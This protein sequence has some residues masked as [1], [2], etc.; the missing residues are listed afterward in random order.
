MAVVQIS[1]IQLRRGKKL[2]SGMPQ[3]A[4]GE[5]AWAID[6]QELYIGNGAVS[7]GAPAVGNTKVL[8]ENDNIL[9]LFDQYQYKPND[10]L[11]QT[12]LD[13][14][15]P[16]QRTLQERLDEGRVNAAS[17]GI[18]GVDDTVDQT[19]LIQNAIYS[20][21]LTTSESNQVALEFD[22]GTYRIT[23]TLYIPSNAYLAGSGKEK[24]VFDFVRGGI[25]SGATLNLLGTSI[26]SAGNYTNL[27]TVTVT[28][29]G[30]G[31]IV[32]VSKTGTGASYTS[33]NTIVTIV[34][35][36]SGYINGDQI[37]ILG[38][39]L[40]GAS[41]TNDLTITLGKRL[42]NPSFDTDTVFEFVNN[43][44]DKGNISTMPS[45]T[46]NNQAKNIVLEGFTVNTNNNSVKVFNF[47]N[48]RNSKIFNVKAKGNNGSDDQDSETSNSPADDGAPLSVPTLIS[49]SIALEMSALSVSYTSS[50]FLTTGN[51]FIDFEAEGFSYGVFSNTEIKNNHFE[52]CTF[53][54]LYMGVSFGENAAIGNNGPIKNQITNCVFDRIARHGMLIAKGYGNRSRGNTFY[55][56]GNNG[57]GNANNVYSQIKFV[58][59]GNTSFQDHFDRAKDLATGSYTEG[60]V[61]EIEGKS[62]KHELVTNSK[63]LST[64]PISVEAFRIPINN[65]SGFEIEYIFKS[66]AYTQM[67]RGK[68]HIAVDSLNNSVQLVDD[69]EYIGTAGQEGNT[70]FTAQL[71]TPIGTIVKALVIYY[72]NINVS[73]TNTFTY[74]YTSLS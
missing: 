21:Y 11:M 70:L 52:K 50:D 46:Y 47:A 43:G 34:N 57:G 2:T 48:V 3:L 23:G 25:N 45:T 9:D 64:S 5:L 39:S 40:G 44:F 17:F 32:N 73:D 19:A 16:V 41:P 42:V 27:S 37:K 24:T 53:K 59:N 29:T 6:T 56:V 7:E 18:S 12:G 51:R 33:S 49:N 31:A 54:V 22:P 67:K 10:P 26:T 13:V 20:L 60:Y 72:K 14:N 38:S 74:T 8:T 4:S 36:G 69:Y 66:T 30:T 65:E 71:V 1:K 58:S 55:N 28:G 68:M 61:P 63:Q 35:S 15:Y 62:F